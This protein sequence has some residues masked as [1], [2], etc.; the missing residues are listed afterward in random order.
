MTASPTGRRPSSASTA[1]SSALRA[2]VSV[3]GP[4]IRKS[5]KRA[6][7]CGTA[8][9]IGDHWTFNV[10]FPRR[11]PGGV[12]RCPPSGCRRHLHRPAVQ[13]ELRHQ[14]RRR[15]PPQRVVRPLP[16]DAQPGLDLRGRRRPPEHARSVER[17]RGARGVPV[18]RS[19]RRRLSESPGRAWLHQLELQRPAASRHLAQRH[20]RRGPARLQR[21]LGT[22]AAR[23]HVGRRS[24][25]SHRLRP[26]DLLQGGDDPG[27][28]VAVQP[29]LGSRREVHRLEHPGLDVLELP[30]RPSGPGTSASPATTTT[31]PRS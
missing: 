8:F 6:S 11:E 25:W 7:S 17:L 28:R 12:E 16:R 23:T 21:V 13:R 24:G 15:T 18:L 30:A 1:R 14:G 20:G 9:Q 29:E 27:S 3:E 26:S 10:G 5:A 19:R 31:S 4:A 22:R 2:P